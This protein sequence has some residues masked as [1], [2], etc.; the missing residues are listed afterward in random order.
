MCSWGSRE[1][2]EGGYSTGGSWQHWG[3]VDAL[4]PPRKPEDAQKEELP[5][6]VERE[7]LVEKAA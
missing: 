3:A 4:S 5:E 6:P 1:T 7:G 2:S